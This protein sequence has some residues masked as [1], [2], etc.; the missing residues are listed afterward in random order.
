MSTFKLGPKIPVRQRYFSLPQ[1]VENPH[2]DHRCKHGLRGINSF[3]AGT[4]ICVTDYEQE[5]IAN[6]ETTVHESRSY[7]VVDDRLSCFDVPEDLAAI[8]ASFD[9]G[10]DRKPTTVR[11]AAVEVGTSVDSFCRYAVKQL[12]ASGKVTIED[13]LD[14]YENSENGDL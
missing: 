2:R 6:G 4:S 14:A 12:L 3:P 8:F 13:L 10:E 5:A 9:P 7:F 11:E 1:T